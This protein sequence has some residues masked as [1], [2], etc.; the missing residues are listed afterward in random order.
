MNGL[1][2]GHAPAAGASS[3]SLSKGRRQP[4]AP[5]VDVLSRAICE[6]NGSVKEKESIVSRGG[7][8]RRAGP[9]LAG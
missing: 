6:L 5:I 1:T 9:Y 4:P 2:A 3:A 8:P 7:E